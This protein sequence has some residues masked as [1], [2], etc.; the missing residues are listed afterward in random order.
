MILSSFYYAAKVC[1]PQKVCY[2]KSTGGRLPAGFY[3]Y[4]ICFD[5]H[6]DGKMNCLGLASLLLLLFGILGI[7]T[8]L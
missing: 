8:F 7:Q 1:Q 2:N 5:N 6:R 3:K 4:N